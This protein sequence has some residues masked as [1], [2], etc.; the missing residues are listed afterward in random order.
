MDFLTSALTLQ[1]GLSITLRAWPYLTF[2][3][4]YLDFRN[5]LLAFRE[6]AQFAA[7][8]DLPQQALINRVVAASVPEEKDR[9][10]MAAGDIGALLEAIFEL[11]RLTDVA[12]KPLSL[13]Q[14]LLQAEMSSLEPPNPPPPDSPA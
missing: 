10:L 4:N 5:L 14:R 13:Y 8:S 2:T 11:N 6:H 9:E 7:D 1:S 3:A 12:A